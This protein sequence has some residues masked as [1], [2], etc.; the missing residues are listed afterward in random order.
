MQNNQFAGWPSYSDDE[1]KAVSNVLL[2]NKVNYW[3]GEECSLFENEFSR[4]IGSNHCIS[5]ANGT[6]ALELALRA[7]NIG[8]NDEVIVTPRSF[9]ASVSSV[10]NVGAKPIFADVDPVSGNLTAQTINSVISDKT[11]AVILVHLAGWPCDMDPIMKLSKKYSFFVIE[12]CAQ[13]HGAKYK[14]QHVGT[15]GHIGAWSFCQDKIMTTGGEGGMVATNDRNLWERMWSYKDHGKSQRAIAETQNKPGFRWL[16]ES[17]GSNFRMTSMQ[18]AIGRI[19]INKMATWTE[20]RNENANFLKMSIESIDPEQKYFVVPSFRCNQNCSK[21]SGNRL[22]R[23][24]VHANYKF[25]VYL[26]NQNLPHSWSRDKV[27]D[28]IRNLGVP[29][30]QGSCSEIYL[31]QAIK[32]CGAAPEKSLSTSKQLGESS[33]MFLVHPTLT[34]ENLEQ[35]KRTLEKVFEELELDNEKSR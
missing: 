31:E 11:K 6:V 16:H 22:N 17:I 4:W 2:S 34:L 24:C 15:I 7:V 32:K 9:I 1:A 25:Y 23:C 29:C 5:L 35:T 10:I 18:A 30:L 28:K 27:V 26:N 3:T 19:Q 12:D 33:L 20:K 8:R 14:G 21:K 13:A